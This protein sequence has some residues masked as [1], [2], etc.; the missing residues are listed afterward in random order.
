MSYLYW[1][2]HENPCNCPKGVVCFC[3]VNTGLICKN[4][5][6]NHNYASFHDVCTIYRFDG[7][8]GSIQFA[9]IGISIIPTVLASLFL[10][11]I[12]LK[13][14]SSIKK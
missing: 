8:Y 10:S 4:A 11:I 1:T 13:Q 12:Y 6:D 9:S 7:E 3:G 2:N 5:Y 14:K